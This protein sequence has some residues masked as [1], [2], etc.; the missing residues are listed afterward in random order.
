MEE[1]AAKS[2]EF[3]AEIAA[4]GSPETLEEVRVRLLGRSGAITL[5]MR[6]LG[7]L[8]AEERREA[9]ARLNRLRDDVTAAIE[10]A[11]GKLRRA[12]LANRLAG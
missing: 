1:F 8:P 6:E 11:G 3:L 10:E 7:R 5:L 2:Q 4:A 9:G 12:A